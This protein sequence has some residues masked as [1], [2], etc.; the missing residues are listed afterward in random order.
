MLELIHTRCI[1]IVCYED[2]ARAAPLSSASAVPGR[3]CAA[4]DAV[5]GLL[6]LQVIGTPK[7]PAQQQVRT[8]EQMHVY[9]ICLDPVGIHC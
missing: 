2:V 7:C 5:T 3:M 1:E 4:L 6:E 9:R 8:T